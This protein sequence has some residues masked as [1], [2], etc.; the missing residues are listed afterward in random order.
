MLSVNVCVLRDFP[1][2]PSEMALNACISKKDSALFADELVCPIEKETANSDDKHGK[3]EKS[4][5]RR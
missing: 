1:E 5:A 2:A 3:E 4:Y